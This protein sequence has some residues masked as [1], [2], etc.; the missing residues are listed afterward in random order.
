[1]RIKTSVFVKSS[2]S[3][4]QCPSRDVPEVALIG[5]SNV[6]KSSLINMLLGRRHLAK[7]SGRPGK[8]QLINHFLV[9]DA[10]HLVDLPGYGWAQV[11]KKQR[12]QWPSMIKQYL[13]HRAQL[14]C[15]LVLLD[16]RLPPQKTDLAF[17]QWLG[18]HQVPFALV[19]TKADKESKQQARQN[20]AAL[21]KA[22]RETWEELPT[23]MVTS[24][25]DSQGREE[26]LEY[27]QQ[28]ITP[29]SSKSFT[30][31]TD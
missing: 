13:V 22:L 17:I 3:Y 26:V 31:A 11:S 16:T 28:I 23:I 27:I 29:N 14:H 24:S 6:G 18:E 2:A 30:F 19:F 1:M 25:R 20:Q 9:N 10:W 4:Q 12:Q 21:Q 7:V 5:R 15:V 8:T